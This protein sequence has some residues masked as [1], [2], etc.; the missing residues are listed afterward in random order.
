MPLTYGEVS[1][2]VRKNGDVAVMAKKGATVT[3]LKNGKIDSV[4]FVEKDATRFKHGRKWYTRKE[5][6]KRVEEG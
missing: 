6:E 1:K 3:L 4:A 2:F 5:F